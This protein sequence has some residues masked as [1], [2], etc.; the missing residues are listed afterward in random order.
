MAHRCIKGCGTLIPSNDWH[1]E[2]ENCRAVDD[3]MLK[4]LEEEQNESRRDFHTIE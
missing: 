1:A 3:V 4:L 2:C